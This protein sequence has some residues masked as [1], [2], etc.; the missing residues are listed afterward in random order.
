VVK[1]AIEAVDRAINHVRNYNFKGASV[2]WK[3]KVLNLK[4]RASIYFTNAQYVCAVGLLKISQEKGV[5]VRK[6]FW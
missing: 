6:V 3:L 2:S 4:K 1:I 5:R